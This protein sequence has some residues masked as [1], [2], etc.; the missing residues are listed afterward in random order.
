MSAWSNRLGTPRRERRSGSS[1]PGAFSIEYASGEEEVALISTNDISS[2]APRMSLTRDDEK[3]A[4]S[5]INLPQ[6]QHR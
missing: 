5:S 1:T 6:L 2:T 4:T 3:V